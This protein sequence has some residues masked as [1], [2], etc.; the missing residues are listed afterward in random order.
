[1]GEETE[2]EKH[3]DALSSFMKRLSESMTLEEKK[4]LH[5]RIHE[6]W[7]KDPLSRIGPL[8]IDPVPFVGSKRAI[9]LKNCPDCGAKPGEPHALEGGCDVEPCS[10]CGGQRL[11][12]EGDPD[13]ATH[14][15]YFARWT[16]IWP[17]E[18]ECY[19]L[20]LIY[21]DTSEASPTKGYVGPDLNEFIRRGLH[22]LFFVKRPI[23]TQQ[24]EV[25]GEPYFEQEWWDVIGDYRPHPNPKR[26]GN[27][28]SLSSEVETLA[29]ANKKK[30]SRKLPRVRVIV[31][32][33]K[34]EPPTKMA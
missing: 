32:V 18:A 11:G 27:L 1:M 29:D 20:G 17:G 28:I 34:E 3:I 33:L 12:C 31:E 22:K 10:V 25:I 5:Q 14:D 21:K 16:G 30:Y 9:E 19:A 2:L 23:A 7:A 24:I 26:S 6:A 4:A 8:G 13:C 15:P